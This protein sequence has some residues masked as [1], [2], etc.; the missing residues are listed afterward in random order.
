MRFPVTLFLV[1]LALGCGDGPTEPECI[2]VN[3]PVVSAAGD[4]VGVVEIRSCIKRVYWYDKEG[5]EP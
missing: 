3:T 5:V 2:D 1:V 4:T